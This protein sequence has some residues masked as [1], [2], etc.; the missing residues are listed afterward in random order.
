MAAVEDRASIL[1]VEDDPSIARMTIEVL[2]ETY[3]VDH[4][5]DAPTGLARALS[6]PYDLILLDRRLPG[7]DGIELVTAIRRAHITTPVLLL[8]ALGAVDDRVSGLDAGANDYLVKPFDFDELLARLRALR[9]GF[10]AEGR[11][12]PIGDWTHLPDAA[13]VFSPM[14]E[15]IA[16]TET[17]NALLDMLGSSPDHVFSR[18]ELLAGVFRAGESPGSVDTYVHYVRRKTAPDLIATVRA[19]GYRIGDPE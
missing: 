16:L 5:T 10:R 14:G 7:G 12:R 11:R 13:V 19:R 3:V 17:E 8:T 2:A 1:Y 6:R 18:E 9:R 4:V 15:R